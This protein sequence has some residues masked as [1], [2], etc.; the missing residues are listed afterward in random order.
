MSF[1][2]G[3]IVAWKWGKGVAEG[4]VVEEFT[5]DIQ[6]SIKGANVK[7][8][9]TEDK[10]AYLIRQKNGSEVLKSITE[11]EERKNLLDEG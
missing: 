7:R 10:P 11:I 4:E 2:L 5:D 6:L 8:L 1:V 9:A 3:D